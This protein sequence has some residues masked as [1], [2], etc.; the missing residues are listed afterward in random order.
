MPIIR[1]IARAIVAT[2]LCSALLFGCAP[3]GGGTGAVSTP[4]NVLDPRQVFALV[5]DKKSE[6]DI[7]SA[8]ASEGYRVLDKTNLAGLGL[9]MLSIEMTPGVSGKEAINRLESA[10]PASVVGVNHIYRPQQQ[11]GTTGTLDYAGEMMKWPQNG[12][13][14]QTPVGIIDTRID[15]QASALGSAQIVTRQFFEGPATAA[16]HGTNVAT[17]LAGTG[18]LTDVTL[19]GADVF[20][21]EEG[22]GLAAGADALI[23]ALD[24]MAG[25]NVRFVNLALAGPYN[26]L[27]DLAVDR[28]AKRGMILVAA[29]GNDGP[30]A[31]PL[32][33]AGFESVIA[34]TAVD[35]NGGIYRKAVRGP[36]VDVAAPGVD[37]LLDTGSAMRLVSGTSIATP[38]VTAR[39]VGDQSLKNVRSVDGVR[40]HLAATSTELGAP[41]RDSLFGY[42]LVIAEGICGN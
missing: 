31:D 24:W 10:V 17:V 13:R 19:Y 41:G 8:A 5:P 36:H 33:P 12:C 28:A 30:R 26:K 16:D 21:R 14:A 39:L 38:F 20:G 6:R 23:K 42:G 35:V 40:E 1:V 34:V 32:Y 37:I 4:S 7:R 15:T 22:V 25:E 2:S 9:T 18:R 11:S 29:V 3:S 27:L